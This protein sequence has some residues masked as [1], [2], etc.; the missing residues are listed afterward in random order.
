MGLFDFLRPRKPL[1][2][3]EQKWNKLWD[4]WEQGETESP[5]TQLM[6]YESEVNNGGHS[7]Y[8]F[9]TANCGDLKAEVE[10]LLSVLPEPLQTNLK[11]AYEEFSN[12]E[13][14]CDDENEELFEACDSVF[15]EHEHLLIALLQSHADG[16]PL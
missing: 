3:A 13:D 5:Y 9:N 4:L 8:F 7:Q 10:V 16:M 2:E 1:T 11:K 6:E 15:Y 14:I 12:Q